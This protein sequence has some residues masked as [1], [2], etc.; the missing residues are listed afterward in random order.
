MWLSVCGLPSVIEDEAI[1]GAALANGS[2]C[3]MVNWMIITLTKF[4]LIPYPEAVIVNL[5]LDCWNFSPVLYLNFNKRKTQ[6]PF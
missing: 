1:T 6:L 3:Y 5:S 2:K 4:L